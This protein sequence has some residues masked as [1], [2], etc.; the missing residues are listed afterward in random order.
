[1]L[2][3]LDASSAPEEA[4]ALAR[5]N[6]EIEPVIRRGLG[7]K[8]RFYRRQGDQDLQRPEFDEIYNDIHLRLLKRLRSLKQDPDQK[9]ILN[10]RHYVA[11]VTRNTCDEYL[12]QRYP[13]RRSLKDK[14]RRHLLSHP[15]FALWEDTEH[16]WLAGLSGGQSLGRTLKDE[17]GTGELQERLKKE[18]QTVGVQRLE[19][20]NLLMTI[21][22]VVHEPMEL[23]QLTELVAGFWGIEDHPAEALAGDEWAPF[24]QGADVDH[25]TII[26][27]RQYL[28][29]LW[30]E[31]CQLPRRQRVALLFN[32]RSPHGINVITL[33]P[34]T[35]VA[36]FEQ[37]AQALEIPASEFEQLWAEL[38]L[39]DL[40]VAAY[41]GA[42]RQQV[43]NLRKTARERLLKRMSALS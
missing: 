42:T 29:L 17:R 9:Q 21:F 3:F 32:L 22:G 30:R 10:L 26:E 20:H 1:L 4:A 39:D 35:G 36:T 27:Q 19:L 38:P 8:L 23:D 41:L 15:E 11:T 6:A 14:V 31:I 33:F 37:I 2:E 40:R 25:S 28:Q 5:L 34:V 43:I 18:W 13:L 24:E 7:Y 12:R 16:N